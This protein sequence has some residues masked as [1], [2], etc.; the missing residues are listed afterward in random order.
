V[1]AKETAVVAKE[2]QPEQVTP[3]KEAQPERVAPKQPPDT[4]VAK[5]QLVDE[6]LAAFPGAELITLESAD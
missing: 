2:I 1:V 4:G 3:T 5:Q 6:L